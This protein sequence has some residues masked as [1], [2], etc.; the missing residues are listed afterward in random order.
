[1]SAEL[2]EMVSPLLIPW[3]EAHLALKYLS[4]FLTLLYEKP[5]QHISENS[6]D[7]GIIPVVKELIYRL[8][9][10]LPQ[11]TLRHKRKLKS[12]LMRLIQRQSVRFSGEPLKG[13]QIMGML[14]TRLLDFDTLIIT[15]MNE[16]LLPQARSQNS[17]IPFDVRHYFALPMPGD[18]ENVFAYHF[19]RLLANS[20]RIILLYNTDTDTFGS[21]GK[22]RYL[23]QLSRELP[24]KNP[25]C[26]ITE[27]V[28]RLPPVPQLKNQD[29]IPKDDLI[30][31]KLRLIAGT[32]Y[33]ASHFMTYFSCPVKFYHQYVLGLAAEH[34]P[35]SSIDSSTLGS[36]VHEV[37]QRIYEHCL[38]NDPYAGLKE[39]NALVSEYMKQAMQ[40]RLG[41]DNLDSGENFLL[42]EVAS[43]VV[44]RFIEL[45]L[46]WKQGSQGFRQL[47]SLEKRLTT[48][49]EIQ[50]SQILLKGTIDRIDIDNQGRIRIIDYKSGTVGPADLKASLDNLTKEDGSYN[51]AFQLQFYT[52]L[53]L[54]NNPGHTPCQAGIFSLRNLSAGFI[55]LQ[56]TNDDPENVEILHLFEARITEL[57]TEILDPAMP[58]TYTRE[59]RNCNYCDYKTICGRF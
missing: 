54:R 1:M 20:T 39:S 57:I 42:K 24:L 9:A 2:W 43:S 53:Y 58:F 56:I 11:S 16:G 27:Q 23:Q 22:S 35:D 31:D 49:L 14:E 13:L 5:R 55:P 4:E 33:S 7:A 51:K 59:N 12:I 48:T 50:E 37:L 45:E 8:I 32:G 6:L 36:A 34:D 30:M 46:D 40:K 38:Q 29:Y 15:G 21:S 10:A 47:L 52:W 18:K 26:R 3:T 19:Y 28:L 17:F 41:T 25:E 44:R